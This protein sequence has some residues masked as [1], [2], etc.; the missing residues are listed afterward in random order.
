MASNLQTS[1]SPLGLRPMYF[2]HRGQGKLTPMIPADELPQSVKLKNVKTEME[3]C[4]TSGM[5]S[6]GEV[7]P[8]GGHYELET[9][10][11][12]AFS[13]DNNAAGNTHWRMNQVGYIHQLTCLSKLT[14]CS[15]TA[16]MTPEKGPTYEVMAKVRKHSSTTSCVRFK[17]R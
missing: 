12:A 2:L 1:A 11:A 6:V 4:D 10:L 3:L 8:S 16:V 9:P 17:D 5:I 15:K 13:G 14:R 7:P